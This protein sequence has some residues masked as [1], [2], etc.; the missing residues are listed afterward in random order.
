MLNPRLVTILVATALPATLSAQGT[1]TDGDVSFSRYSFEATPLT[2]F[3]GAS[4]VL[5][6]QHLHEFGWW[7]REPGVTTR[8]AH[9]PLPL[10]ETYVGATSTITWGSVGANGLF[11]LVE[12][13][14]VRDAGLPGVGDGGEVE[15]VL[16]VRNE[17][18]ISTRSLE[19]FAL[20]D[21][22]VDGF[23]G[24]SA[25]LYLPPRYLL[26]SDGEVRA[27]VLGS[28]AKAFLVREYDGTN[29]V[30]SLLNDLS[31]TEFDSSGLPFGPGDVT[32]GFQWSFELAPDEE[33]EVVV[34]FSIDQSL[35]CDAGPRA[36]FC[37]RFEEAP[38][39]GWSGMAPA[40]C[41]GSCGGASA[42]ACA[43]D[44]A[45]VGRGDCCLDAC[46]TCGHCPPF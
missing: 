25:E 41:A 39:L 30:A 19:L 8:E 5:S 24:D 17:Y 28:G 44:A 4:P 40:S 18:G 13:A 15:I 27:D 1:I 38:L 12:V 32:I 20:I 37:G 14:T 10:T 46:L 6:R 31:V 22:D 29:D 11:D 3:V 16:T 43:C 36:L 2:G 26:L 45:C 33:K 7:L 23:D 21:L 34:V 35:F 42:S 9:L